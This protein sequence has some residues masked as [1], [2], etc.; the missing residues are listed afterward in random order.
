MV[1]V[2]TF[3]TKDTKGHE[4][5]EGSPQESKESQGAGGIAKSALL[6]YEV[7]S[8]RVDMGLRASGE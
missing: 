6:V 3:T 5:H 4:E 2:K 7:Q 8:A 1:T